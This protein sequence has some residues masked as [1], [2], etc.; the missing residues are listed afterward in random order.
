MKAIF[1]DRLTLT[2]LLLIAAAPLVFGAQPPWASGFLLA[3]MMLLCSIFVLQQSLRG[4]SWSFGSSGLYTN[5]NRFAVL[6]ALCWLCGSAL[7]LESLSR[8]SR[9]LPSRLRQT[10]V[11]LVL[12]AISI[13]IALTLSRLTIA[14][15]GIAL[16]IA[17]A[18]W[19]LL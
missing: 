1:A 5:A 10:F 18:A 14:A 6:M 13:C 8:N 11:L 3:A 16:L 12:L 9:S 19:L 15:T 7:F 17:A 4:E 2:A